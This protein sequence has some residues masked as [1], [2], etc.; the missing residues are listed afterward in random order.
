M[1]FYYTCA[2]RE[3]FGISGFQ[4]ALAFQRREMV[5]Y[6]VIDTSPDSLVVGPEKRLLPGSSERPVLQ[7][8]EREIDLSGFVC[9]I[10]KHHQRDA[11]RDANGIS[12]ECGR[13]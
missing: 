13:F 1:K 7:L 3:P 2:C 9:Y 5:R 6:R 8:I 4:R 12:R 11:G 10:N